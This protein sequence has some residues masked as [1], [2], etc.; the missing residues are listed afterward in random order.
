MLFEKKLFADVL[1]L[2]AEMFVLFIAIG[3]CGS[4]PENDQQ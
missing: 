2:R 3:R 1:Q 4:V